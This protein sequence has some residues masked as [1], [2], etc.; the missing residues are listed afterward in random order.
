MS[1]GLL[2]ATLL[3][4]AAVLAFVFILLPFRFSIRKTAT[5]LAGGLVL[6]C[7]AT[8]LLEMRYGT[9]F[10][11]T[12][13][14]F[15]IG[16]PLFA[17]FYFL[18]SAKGVRFL[19]V[20]LT[21]LIFHII[22]CTLLLAFRIHEG[23]FTSLYFLM[24]FAAFGAL[25]AGTYAIRADLHKIV[26]TYHWEFSCLAVILL[27]LLCIIIVFSPVSGGNMVDPDLLL[28][29]GVLSLLVVLLY[30]YVGISF[31][32]LG[33]RVDAERDALTLRLQVEEAQSN[34]ALLRSSQESAAFYRHD[35][36]HHL[37]L[38]RT[39]LDNG[40]IQQLRDYLDE[41]QQEVDNSTPRRHCQN[42]AANLLISAFITKAESA[43]VRLVADT[44]IPHSLPISN[45]ELCTLLSNALENAIHGAVSAPAEVE[46]LV[47]LMVRQTDG[48][49]L[50]SVENPYGGEVAM[51]DGLP[52][53]NRA[54]HGMG[55]RSMK[56]IVKNYGGLSTFEAKDGIF[57]VRIAV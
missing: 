37:M 36:R 5:I 42:D 24:N 2:A 20:M 15:L 33:K 52:Q 31:H 6:L 49:L 27:L 9:S 18:S 48:K 25:L 21:S 57:T 12:Y 39:L 53:S 56:M 19:F 8:V 3:Q 13:G 1:M 44:Q 29:F 22:L 40:A 10:M 41:V 28:L 4:T 47:R 51:V 11:L 45:P 14:F 7:L 54:G 17:M 30:V 16:G 50:L 23:G 35:L 43:G 38:I 46:K 34:I 26:L 32:S 55:T